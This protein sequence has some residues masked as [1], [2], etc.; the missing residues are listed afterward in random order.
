VDGEGRPFVVEAAFAVCEDHG[1]RFSLR[2]GVNWSPSLSPDAAL[3]LWHAKIDEDDPVVLAVH[4]VTP[5]V[6]YTDPAKSQARLSGAANEAVED[7]VEKATAPWTRMKKGMA[8]EDRVE[9]KDLEGLA[10]KRKGP[11]LIQAAFRVMAE[12]HAHVTG[13][14]QGAPA[15]AR[16]LMYAARKLMQR[17]VGTRCWRKSS[18]FTQKILPAYMEAHPEET[19]SWNVV[20][21]ARGELIEPHGG[22][23]VALGTVAVREYLA[24]LDVDRYRHVLLVEKEGFRDLI[25]HAG[26]AN[27]YDVALAWTKGMS[28]TA[29]RE[30]VDG[31]SGLGVTTH[32]LHD[33]DTYGLSICHTLCHDSP[34][35]RFK[36][37]PLVEDVG[38]RLAD[39][40]ALGLEGE[41][42]EYRKRKKDPRELLVKRGV[43][44]AERDYLVRSGPPYRGRR[45]ELN[46]LTNEQ[47]IAFIE[48]KLIEAGVRKVVPEVGRLRDE[49]ARAWRAGRVRRAVEEAER[50]AWEEVAKLAPP[51]P[52]NLQRAVRK[53]IEGTAD[54]WRSAVRSMAAATLS[55]EAER[56][57]AR[58]PTNG[59]RKRRPPGPQ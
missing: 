57:G 10:R 43:P 26:I 11:T 4:V 42:V 48:R 29:A 23:R 31:L 51:V 56:S 50:K 7:A 59:A 13:G 22:A 1:R 28:T 35:Y 9:E 5:R 49:F 44:K 14:R 45:A 47:L 12:A 3:L 6:A 34:R 53:N 33:C 16:Q 41:E 40:R 21:D 58:R 32:V 20:Y 36:N 8:R 52:A 19:A 17:L 2:W 37:K 30:L 24:R 55:R 39:L 46:E 54:D 38:L 27:R 18:Q 15:H 25:E